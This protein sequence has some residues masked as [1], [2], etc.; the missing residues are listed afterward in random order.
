MINVSRND[1]LPISPLELLQ[2]NQIR[3]LGHKNISIL[4]SVN[5]NIIHVNYYLNKLYI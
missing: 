3:N 5:A 1:Q 2:S 4:Y